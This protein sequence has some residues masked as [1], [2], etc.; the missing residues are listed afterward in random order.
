[1]LLSSLSSRYFAS[2]C[3]L[4]WRVLLQSILVLPVLFPSVAVAAEST[5]HGANAL[6]ETKKA[7]AFGERPS[8][9][10]AIEQLRA[11]IVSALKPLGGKIEMDSFGGQTPTGPVPMVNIIDKFPGTSGNIVVVAGHYD[12]KKIPMMNFVGANDGGSSAGFLLE[13]ARAVSSMKH[14]DD[15]Y[16]AFFDGEEAVGEWSETD[17]RYGSRHLVSKWLADGTLPKIKALVNI[18]MIGDKNLDISNDANSSPQLRQMVAKIAES[19]GDSQYFK[20]D[21]RG[22]IDDDHV[23]F[24]A[25]GVNSIDLIDFDYGPGNSYWHQASDTVDKLSAHSFQ[26]TGDVVL[27][28]VKKLDSE[29]TK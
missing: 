17:S 3:T 7:V 18:D 23:P 1:M 13:F 21:S 29:T 14:Q 20:Q 8:G 28:L 9:S 16:V 11:H 10:A 4:R 25:N 22:G 24:V 15:I 19:L 6:L 2:V 5:F 26:V 27:A 12:T